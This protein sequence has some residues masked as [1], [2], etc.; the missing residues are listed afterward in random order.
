MTVIKQTGHI[1]YL[2]GTTFCGSTA[3]VKQ[4]GL[5]GLQCPECYEIARKLFYKK[6]K[7][8]SIRRT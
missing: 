3:P 1:R 2:D 4:T 8:E 7:D 6:S 5:Y